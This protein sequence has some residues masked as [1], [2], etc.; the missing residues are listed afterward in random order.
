MSDVLAKISSYN[1]F[2]YLFPGAVFGVLGERV[3]LLDVA[4]HDV[5]TRLI[6]YY[7][8]GLCI[9]RVGSVIVEPILKGIKFVRE[10]PYGDYLKA[11]DK[12]SE[13]SVM[14]EVTNTYRTLA[15]GFLLL[16]ISIG[17]KGAADR[18]HLTDANRYLILSSALA[19]LFF[20]SYRKQATFV[21]RRVGHYAK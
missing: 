15:A 21:R 13:M 10:A 14:V 12:D 3:H 18:L 4:T 6:L 17:I 20:F 9:S 5:I 11:S 19:V 8:F 1:I 16:P 2:N 7:F